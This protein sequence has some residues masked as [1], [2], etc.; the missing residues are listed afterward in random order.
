MALQV[1]CQRVGADRR[2]S[3]LGHGYP[4]EASRMGG[5]RSPK[6][7]ADRNC[8]HRLRLGFAEAF[9]SSGDVT[10][11]VTFREHRH[12]RSSASTS[13]T[14]SR[15]TEI[16]GFR[17][18]VRKRFFWK[19][20]SFVLPSL[21]DFG[22]SSAF[23]SGD[24]DAP[25]RQLSDWIQARFGLQSFDCIRALPDWAIRPMNTDCPIR[26]SILRDPSFQFG[27]LHRL[28][29]PSSGLV[30][31]ATTYAKYYA[32]ELQLR[33]GLLNRDLAHKA[34]QRVYNMVRVETVQQ[35]ES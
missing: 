20:S 9:R 17:R 11:R 2:A 19:I 10:S 5:L 21:V 35:H 4:H 32:L 24:C 23:S 13:L 3:T 29:V 25:A 1:P 14:D 16:T 7:E 18:A 30:C 27:F 22:L 15:S 12:P 28:D 26:Q 6:P 8:R 31:V 33:T 34:P